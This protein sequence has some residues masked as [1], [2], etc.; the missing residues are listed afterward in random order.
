[1]PEEF[2]GSLDDGRLSDILNNSI[3]GRGAFRRFKD[4]IHRYGIAEDW[5]RYRD[6]SLRK[7]AIEWCEEN[8]INY[9][10]DTRKPEGTGETEQVAKT[11]NWRRKRLKKMPG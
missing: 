10:D 2:C 7:I 3:Q 11:C 9:V 5:Y 4:N 8:G 1:M 6:D